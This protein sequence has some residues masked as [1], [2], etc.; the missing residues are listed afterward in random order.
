MLPRSVALDNS[1]TNAIVVPASHTLGALHGRNIPSLAL[2][3]IGL[4]L[5]SVHVPTCVGV[6]HTLKAE[7]ITSR[8]AV[9]GPLKA[10]GS[11]HARSLSESN[12]ARPVVRIASR[13]SFTASGGSRAV[14]QAAS[15][16]SFADSSGSNTAIKLIARQSSVD[17]I[18]LESTPR[19]LKTNTRSKR[20]GRTRYQS[21][22]NRDKRRHRFLSSLNGHGEHRF[23]L[24]CGCYVEQDAFDPGETPS[25]HWG[26]GFDDS[27]YQTSSYQHLTKGT[28]FRLELCGIHVTTRSK[29]QVELGT[30]LSSVG[31]RAASF[32][33]G[34]GYTCASPVSCPPP[35][36]LVPTRGLPTTLHLR[37][38]DGTGSGKF[39]PNTENSGFSST[40]LKRK[41]PSSSSY[42]SYTPATP[43][44]PFMDD[45]LPA[46][47][48]NHTRARS[49]V[50]VGC[51][52]WFLHDDDPSIVGWYRR[53]SS[54]E[55]KPT[56]IIA[57]LS[58]VAEASQESDPSYDREGSPKR[59]KQS[60]RGSETASVVTSSF[61]ATS[62]AASSPSVSLPS[63]VMSPKPPLVPR[64]T[65]SSPAS[66]RGSR[67]SILLLSR[68][69]SISSS[70]GENSWS[71]SSGIAL[72]PLPVSPIPG[73]EARLSFA[74]TPPPPFAS[75]RNSYSSGLA[76]QTYDS[77]LQWQGE[78][79]DEGVDD[80]SP[81]TKRRRSTG[82][83]SNSSG[84][85]G[86]GDMSRESTDE[87][88]ASLDFDKSQSAR[89]G[90][91]FTARRMFHLGSRASAPTSGSPS[92]NLMG[93]P[94]NPSIV[95]IDCPP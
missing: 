88:G 72:V 38:R 83:S 47:T 90:T 33:S 14:V 18:G 64:S 70:N 69:G 8:H 94:A 41:A 49:R 43:P 89:G 35:H 50:S 16:R 11:S 15:K 39:T 58:Q 42:S 87:E 81:P 55:V 84:G 45:Y 10:L 59:Y 19:E 67:V 3:I 66:S 5:V 32:D 53:R 60:P 77:A 46:A 68:D 7:L 79:N 30:D 27:Y 76:A 95:F 75:S 23:R 13:R 36:G 78:S 71:T 25:F 28:R 93:V 56:P 9:A 63:A 48:S 82:S 2:E 85:F 51:N 44:S 37:S 52:G 74:I 29:E 80:C 1:M 12:G 73:A 24:F 21:G 92:T 86:L 22:Q 6:S 4:A 26:V 61:P 54:G 65:S 91:S 31:A 62:P 17:S 40:G 57:H 20:G 34:F